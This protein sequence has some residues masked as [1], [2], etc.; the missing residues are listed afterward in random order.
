MSKRSTYLLST[1]S[2]QSFCPPVCYSPPKKVLA[3][4]QPFASKICNC[5]ALPTFE[6]F[7]FFIWGI[8][9]ARSESKSVCPVP[10]LERSSAISWPLIPKSPGIQRN[11]A[12]CSLVLIFRVLEHFEIKFTIVIMFHKSVRAIMLLEYICIL[13]LSHSSIASWAV[14]SIC[15]YKLGLQYRD[16]PDYYIIIHLLPPPPVD[17]RF[18]LSW[19]HLFDG[20]PHR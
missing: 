13:P 15:I 1:Q 5:F 18:R 17:S 20:F 12:A 9:T 7:W 19:I 14:V 16:I 10:T 3:N 6:K 8:S 4:L 2:Q 11:S